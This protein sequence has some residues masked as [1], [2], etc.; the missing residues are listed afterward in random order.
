MKIDW[1]K[2]AGYLAVPGTN[3]PLV[4]CD[5]GFQD[6]NSNSKFPVYG[7][8]VDFIGGVSGAKGGS[9]SQLEYWESSDPGLRHPEHPVQVQFAEQRFEYLSRFIPFQ[10]VR[11][12]LD[13][14]SGN[15]VGTISLNRRVDTVFGLDMSGYLLNQMPDNIVGIRADAS[16]LPL[17]DKSV[18]LSMAWELI[19]HIPAPVPVII[20]MSRVTRKWIVLFEP[21]RWNPLQ[22]G[23]S[24]VV[25]KER[26]GLRNTRAYLTGILK[27]AGLNIVHYDTVGCIWPNKSP[28]WLA[29]ILAKVPFKI[30]YIGISHLLIAEVG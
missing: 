26:L 1:W 17:R 10:D 28:G 20:E 19:H 2:T 25:S 27:K 8:V 15:G 30:P 5:G 13:V 22:A 23:F 14:G 24:F 18:D 12:A 4:Y 6:K 7:H 16:R 21:N 9:T 11:S 3:I 29:K